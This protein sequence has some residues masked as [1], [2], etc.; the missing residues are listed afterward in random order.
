MKYSRSSPTLTASP[1]TF[2]SVRNLDFSI[3]ERQPRLFFLHFWAND[4]AKKLAQGLRA[5]LD[6]IN[7]A[8]S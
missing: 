7:I 5:A 3:G 1:A 8:K 2:L 4:D 6:H